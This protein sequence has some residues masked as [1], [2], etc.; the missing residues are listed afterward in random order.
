MTSV[1]YDSGPAGGSPASPMHS[2]ALSQYPED[3]A[4]PL[5]NHQIESPVFRRIQKPEQEFRDFFYT[6]QIIHIAR[7]V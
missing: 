1:H 7:M 4:R 3:H 5:E 2:T 6:H